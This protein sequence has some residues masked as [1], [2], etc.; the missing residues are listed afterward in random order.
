[1]EGQSSQRHALHCH[2]GTTRCWYFSAYAGQND[3]PKGALPYPCDRADCTASDFK[4]AHYQFA[5]EKTHS[6]QLR[7][8]VVVQHNSLGP[9]TLYGA[10]K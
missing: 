9:R 4:W 8:S 10:Q 6:V 5:T 7:P 3:E 1:M 2:R